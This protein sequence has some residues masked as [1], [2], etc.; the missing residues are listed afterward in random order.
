M[1]VEQASP[2][3]LLMSPSH[4]I[5]FQLRGSAVAFPRAESIDRLPQVA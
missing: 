1:H 3:S 2:A 4:A 5:P